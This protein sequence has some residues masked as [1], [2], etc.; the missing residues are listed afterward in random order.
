VGKLMIYDDRNLNMYWFT[1]VCREGGSDAP[2]VFVQHGLLGVSL[3]I[4]QRHRWAHPRLYG[5]YDD[6]IQSRYRV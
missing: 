6:V 1:A 2:H 3:P 4:P 5:E